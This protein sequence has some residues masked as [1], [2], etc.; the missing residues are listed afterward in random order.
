M[1]RKAYVQGR[2]QVSPGEEDGEGKE[3]WTPGWVA[4]C[5]GGAVA[6]CS[7]SRSTAIISFLRAFR[8][9]GLVALIIR[10]KITNRAIYKEKR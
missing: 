3:K 7:A 5:G 9:M 4:G 8:P 6:R 2:R 10:W 1:K